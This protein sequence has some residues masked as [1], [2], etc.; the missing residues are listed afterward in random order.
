V[1]TIIEILKKG[2]KKWEKKIR[3]RQKA[4]LQELIA[5]WEKQKVPHV[6]CPFPECDH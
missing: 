1:A 6:V 5:R 4:A 3:R 2:A